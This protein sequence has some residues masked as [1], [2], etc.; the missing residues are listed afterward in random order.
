[1]SNPFAPTASHDPRFFGAWRLVGVS[2]EDVATGKKLDE[3]VTQT[4][5]ISYTR[6]GRVMVIISREAPGKPAEVTCY[7]AA[8][9]VEGEHVIHDVDIAARAAWKGTRQLRGFRFHGDRLTLSPPVSPDYVHGSV[10]RRSLEW[11]KV[12]PAS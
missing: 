4:G 7:A 9:H 8:W 1:M 6:D 5:Y 11:Q 3:D 10:T 12:L 2:R